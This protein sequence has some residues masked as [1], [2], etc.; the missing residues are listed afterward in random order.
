MGFCQ[1][2]CVQITTQ[3]RCWHLAGL[4]IGILSLAGRAVALAA[5]RDTL[6]VSWHSGMP[7]QYGEQALAYSSLS[8]SAQTVLHTGRLCISPQSRLEWF[9]FSDDGILA[10]YDSK[11]WRHL[12]A[13]LP[14]SFQCVS[15]TLVMKGMSGAQGVMRIHSAA[16]GGS[17]M[18]VFGQPTGQSADKVYWPVGLSC[19]E[20]YCITCTTSNPKPRVRTG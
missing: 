1:I 17:W 5:H 18:P 15:V 19:S 20:F 16:F 2:G 7:A 14:C 8:V 10:A 4:Q 9:G 12:L 13:S 11:V 3:S 6:A